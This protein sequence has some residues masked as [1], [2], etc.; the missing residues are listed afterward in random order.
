MS[1]CGGNTGKILSSHAILLNVY[2]ASLNGQ[3]FQYKD[4]YYIMEMQFKK[5]F[6]PA[7]A[8]RTLPL[9]SRIVEDILNLGHEIR[10]LTT[11]VG[12]QA[13]DNPQIQELMEQLQSYLTELEEVGCFY[14]DWNFSIGL[15]DFPTVIDE[16]EVFLCWRSDEDAIRYYHEI[17]AG[18]AGRKLI[19]AKYLEQR[20]DTW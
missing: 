7:E 12:E 17:D 20:E 15:V 9:V 5:Y 11:M 1:Q 4:W 18:Y 8:E 14:K 6:T 2:Y 16:K 19:P 13:P 3:L 10:S